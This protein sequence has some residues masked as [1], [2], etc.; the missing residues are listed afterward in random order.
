VVAPVPAPIVPADPANFATMFGNA[1]FQRGP[2]VL[3]MLEHEIGARAFEA[4]LRRYV[5]EHRHGSVATS[6]FQRACEQ[7]SGKSLAAFFGRWVLGNAAL[8]R[9][10]RS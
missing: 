7:A 9:V 10:N 8:E 1:T 2:A 5:A 4:A 6:D 3:V